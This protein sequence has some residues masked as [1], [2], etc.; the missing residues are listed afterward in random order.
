MLFCVTMLIALAVACERLLP[1]PPLSDRAPATAPASAASWHWLR[2][3]A[4][5][6]R[7]T[8]R[9]TNPHSATIPTAVSGRIAPRDFFEIRGR[10]ILMDLSFGKGQVLAFRVSTCR[11]LRHAW[12][13]QTSW[14]G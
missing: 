13:V 11:Y 14:D 9:A 12:S 10:C 1:V 2:A 4:S 8:E 5:M 7:S 3:M 6:P